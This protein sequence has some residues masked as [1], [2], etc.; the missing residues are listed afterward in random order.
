MDKK[1]IITIVVGIVAA[2]I[3]GILGYLLIVKFVLNPKGP[4]MPD[5][6]TKLTAEELED[7]KNENCILFSYLDREHKTYYFDLTGTHL[8]DD[9]VDGD[10]SGYK[11]A[12]IVEAGELLQYFN[13]GSFVYENKKEDI[14]VS[15]ITLP[16]PEPVK[17]G[18]DKKEIM[19]IKVA[20]KGK[21]YTFPVNSKILDVFEND[22]NIFII[23]DFGKDLE[24]ST[25]IS[26]NKRTGKADD[27][28][29][30]LIKNP[31]LA[32]VVGDVAYIE[33]EGILKE[34]SLSEQKILKTLE[35]PPTASVVGVRGGYFVKDKDDV[36]FVKPSGISN[37]IDEIKEKAVTTFKVPNGVFG[38]LE[39]KAITVTDNDKE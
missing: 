29:D 19:N 15:N 37:S 38:V 28:Q 24:S 20:I 25:L 27:I 32:G 10:V 31:R 14:K 30:L 9:E 1:K 13:E 12:K 5:D 21:D 7:V 16:S 3:I 8:K 18:E 4:V 34:F 36:Y 39:G 35:V 6:P 26:I 23:T 33:T 11:V 17:D 2:L 22:T